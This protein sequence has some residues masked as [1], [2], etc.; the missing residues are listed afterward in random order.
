MRILYLSPR[1]C[2]PV[3]SGGRL[4]DYQLARQLSRHARVTYATVCPPEPSSSPN[5]AS[6][7]LPS[8]ESQFESYA[9]FPDAKRYSALNLLRGITGP[10]PL[11]VLNWSSRAAARKLAELGRASTFD[12]IQAEGV[13]LLSY[14]P[15]L[16]QFSGK[17]PI[18]CDWHDILSEQMSSYAEIAPSTA[19]KFYARRTASLLRLAETEAL[20]R[21]D[22]HTAVSERDRET[23]RN[24][25]AGRAQTNPEIQ[26]VDNGV[27]SGY[28]SDEALEEAHSLWLRSSEERRPASRRLLFVGAMDYH[29]N[30]D[31]VTRFA[32]DVWPELRKR[33]TDLVFTVVGRHPT[34]QI[35]ELDNRERQ[36]E[37]TGTVP[38]VRPY[39]REAFAAV[40]P[41]RMGSGTR[42]KIL[43]AMAA[44]LPVISTTLGAEGL[45]PAILQRISIANSD[46]EM[47]D[48]VARI[49]REPQETISQAAES[50]MLVR[51]RHDWS[52]I[53]DR[54]FGIHQQLSS[55]KQT[56]TFTSHPY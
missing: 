46:F 35:L 42:L 55:H 4:R 8:P 34:P 33:Y 30:I 18:I 41:L 5:L 23:L 19:R 38:D 48:A 43:E 6:S 15:I 7:G 21:F 3:D 2:W 11:P 36:I 45:D 56:A 31:A 32:R 52:V 22:A 12:T 44:G 47:M 54:L 51:H 10:T 26:V 16:R 28:F 1:R 40:V 24:R 13:H 9:I 20:I 50:R 53:G 37:V 25:V 17:P 27:D 29:A 49:A 14:L 39:Y